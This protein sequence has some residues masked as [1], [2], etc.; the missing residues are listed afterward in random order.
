VFWAD[1]PA[2]ASTLTISNSLL[3]GGNYTLALY[4]AGTIKVTG[5]TFVRGSYQYGP[6]ATNIPVTFT[7]NVYDDGTPLTSC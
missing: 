4:D 2:K 5:N 6:C 3:A 7:G 1:N